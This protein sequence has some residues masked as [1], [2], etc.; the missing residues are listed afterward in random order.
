MAAIYAQSDILLFPS[1]WPEPF[2]RV[3]IE[4]MASGVVVIGTATGGAGEILQ[5]HQNGLTYPPGDELALSEQVLY[6]IQSPTLRKQIS[7][8]ARRVAVEKHDIRS[9]ISGIE[10]YLLT[11]G[12]DI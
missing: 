4:A 6:A 12:N 10:D 1:I 7:H 3:L 2:G 5:D 9:M 8:E 11:I